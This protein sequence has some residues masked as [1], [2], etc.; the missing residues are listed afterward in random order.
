MVKI[1]PKDKKYLITFKP[2]DQRPNQRDDKF[3]IFRNAIGLADI[4]DMLDLKQYTGHHMHTLIRKTRTTVTD[5]NSYELPIIIARLNPDQANR[6]RRDPNIK[7]VEEDGVH[8]PIAEIPGYQIEFVQ[9]APAWV[10]PLSAQGA[11]VNVAIIDDGCYSNHPDLAGHVKVNQDFT[12][13]GHTTP[14]GGNFHGTHCTGIAGAIHNDIGMVGT[15]PMCNLW[16]LKVGTTG[17]Y[18]ISF[19]IE[20]TQYAI[21]NGAHILSESYGSYVLKFQEGDAVAAS[22]S[23]GLIVNATA[24]NT[25]PLTGGGFSPQLL[26]DGG[27]WPSAFPGVNGISNC[28]ELKALSDRSNYGPHVD[29]TSPGTNINST[30]TNNGYALNSGTSMACPCFAGVCATVLSAYVS[31]TTCPP[32]TPGASKRDVVEKVIRDTCTKTGFSQAG[33]IGT[34]DLRFGWGIPQ[35]DKAVAIMKGV[36]ATAI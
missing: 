28:N 30:A 7:Y 9:A 10:P 8:Y 5:I 36:L 13:I 11:G 29:F 2:K 15:A 24:G 12:G 25:Q 14:D 31:G 34:R 6:L 33:A 3:E 23:A 19:I 32:Y 20:A 16:N 35:T 1:D 4:R 17:G 26:P 27:H 22:I 21:Q 18:A